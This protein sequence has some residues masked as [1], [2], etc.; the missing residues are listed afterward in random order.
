MFGKI[1]IGIKGLTPLL[2]NRLVIEDLVKKT[3]KSTGNY[4]LNEAARKSAYITGEG[5]RETLYIPSEAVYRCLLNMAKYYKTGKFKANRILAGTIRIEPEKILLN[6]MDYEV[7]VRPVVIQR[8]RVLRARAKLLEWRADFEIVYDKT[9]IE[10]PAFI[11]D[12]LND[13]GMKSGLLDY[14]PERGGSFGTFTVD[15]FSTKE[16]ITK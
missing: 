13:A 5:K 8:A 2:M 14:R 4:D 6:R 9:T 15:K 7:D 12:I 1:K 16:A 3:T 11:K 10:D